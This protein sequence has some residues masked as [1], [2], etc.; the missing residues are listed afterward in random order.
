[1]RII[2]GLYR[3]KTLQPVPGDS[4]RPIMDRVKAA[5]FDILRPEL[6]ET[7]ILDMFAGAGSIGIEALSQGAASCVFLDLVPKAIETIKRNLEGTSLKER[8]EVRNADAFSYIKHTRKKFDLIFVDPPQF[9]GL[10][11]EALRA[12][13]ERPE[14]LASDTALVIVKIHPDEYEQLSFSSLTEEKVRKYGN[15]LLLFY[16]ANGVAPLL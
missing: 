12:L 10:W 5:L 2:G 13:A 8:A 7:E 16:R 11:I 1:M 9:K 6:A 4:T 3:G 14:I 15:S